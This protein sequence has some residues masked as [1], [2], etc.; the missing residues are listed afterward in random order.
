LL[1]RGLTPEQVLAQ[2]PDLELDDVR[3]SLEFAAREMERP[4]RTTV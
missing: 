1:A 3:A 2:F 4:R